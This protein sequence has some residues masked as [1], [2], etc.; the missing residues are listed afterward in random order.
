MEIRAS[1]ISLSVPDPSASGAWMQRHLGF[2]EA[3]QFEG[4]A[5]LQHSG[6]CPDLALLRVNSPVLPEHLRGHR[7]DG[8]I[9][10][11]VVPSLE[12]AAAG[13]AAQG[14]L[15]TLPIRE[16]PWGERLFQV[17]DPCGIIVQL[18]E[19]RADATAPQ[20]IR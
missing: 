12:A 14:V 4:F 13:L 1:T 6:P 18:V 17:T 11:F 8:V 9:L 19:W 2:T 20:A 16:E 3:L 15:P 5:Y 7:A 10:A